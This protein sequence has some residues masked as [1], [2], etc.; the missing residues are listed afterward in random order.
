MFRVVVWWREY[1]RATFGEAMHLTMQLAD[2][3]LMGVEIHDDSG[4]VLKYR[5]PQS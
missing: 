1:E 3:S 4:L 2:D 5:Q